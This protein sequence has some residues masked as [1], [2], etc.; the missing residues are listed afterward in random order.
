[1][2]FTFK[3]VP[4]QDNETLVDVLVNG[5]VIGQTWRESSRVFNARGLPTPN[6]RNRWF[7]QRA[8]EEDIVGKGEA[9][10]TSRKGDGFFDRF[11]AVAAMLKKDE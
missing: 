9:R 2:S 11:S 3:E 8:G 6:F 10:A 4:D 7:A 5:K 1:M